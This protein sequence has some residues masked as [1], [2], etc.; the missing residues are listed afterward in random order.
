MQALKGRIAYYSI[1]FSE[2]LPIVR[3]AFMDGI[4]VVQG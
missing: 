3:I 2:T 1:S 4:V